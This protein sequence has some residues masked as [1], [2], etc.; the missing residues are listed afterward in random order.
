[1]QLAR[2][3]EE[4]QKVLWFP[5]DPALVEI[6]KKVGDEAT[7]AQCSAKNECLQHQPRLIVGGNGVSG[8]AFV[9]NKA[10]REYAG[11]TFHA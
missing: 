3:H 8:Q 1:V 4:P 11:T 7:L 6:A 9:D 10:F 5:V 2:G